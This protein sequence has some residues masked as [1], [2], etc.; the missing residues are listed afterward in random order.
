MDK[1]EYFLHFNPEKEFFTIS[2]T[3]IIFTQDEIVGTDSLE[4]RDITGIDSF[5][6]EHDQIGFLRDLTEQFEKRGGLQ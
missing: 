3:R 4:I 2:P 6:A 1:R 5:F